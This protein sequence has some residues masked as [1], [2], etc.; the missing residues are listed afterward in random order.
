MGACGVSRQDTDSNEDNFRRKKKKMMNKT[1]K[2]KK[3]GYTDVAVCFM[4]GY[5]T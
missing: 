1:K 5:L 4:W 2:K 3:K